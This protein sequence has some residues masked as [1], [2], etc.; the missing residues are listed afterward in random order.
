MEK[1][2][3]TTMRLPE[4][5]KRLLKQD[6][7]EKDISMNDRLVEILEIYYSMEELEGEQI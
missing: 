1:N 4:K 6:A 2:K 5:I 3:R 7:I